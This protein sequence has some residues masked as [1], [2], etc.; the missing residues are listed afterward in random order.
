MKTQKTQTRSTVPRAKGRYRPVRL[1]RNIA[2]V[3]FGRHEKDR[4][5]MEVWRSAR[6]SPVLIDET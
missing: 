3:P 6:V 2:V 4:R 1:M 5:V